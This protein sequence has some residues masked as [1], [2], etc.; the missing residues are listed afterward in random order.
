MKSENNTNNDQTMKAD[1][2]SITDIKSELDIIFDE[3]IQTG[4]EVKAILREAPDS[5]FQLYDLGLITKE[6]ENDRPE[7][8]DVDLDDSD[9]AKETIIKEVF[10][11][12]GIGDIKYSTKAAQRKPGY[13]QVKMSGSEIQALISKLEKVNDLKARFKSAALEIKDKDQ[14]FDILH[15][16]HYKGL[17]TLS[18]YRR[19]NYFQNPE[20]INFIWANKELINKVNVP[21]LET[22]LEK[23]KAWK[24]NDS[25]WMKM[26][27]AEIIDLKS[28]SNKE[29][30]RFIRETKVQPV[31]IVDGK[32]I[33]C[34]S[35]FIILS[36]GDNNPSIK[37]LDNYRLTD[38]R[39]GT[40]K[41]RSNR[42]LII[43]RLNLY[44]VN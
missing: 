44:L 23:S 39:T 2:C 10:E 37:P 24:A 22:K 36:S 41:K 3:L 20:R 30:L 8:I 1:A 32:Q 19:I 29:N 42:R 17:I 35:P 38:Q 9:Q 31:A 16:R 27:D 14:R 25:D 15:E 43:E 40:G 28:V 33:P 26:V 18:V 6:A 34:P 4:N 11:Y 12:F 13:I 21:Q 5:S 7:S